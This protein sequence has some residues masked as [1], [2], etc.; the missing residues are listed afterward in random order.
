MSG[1]VASKASMMSFS[2]PIASGLPQNAYLMV[3]GA[4][5]AAMPNVTNTLTKNAKRFI[6]CAPFKEIYRVNGVP[7]L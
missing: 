5:D 4:A 2:T 6:L 7:I 3:T 1:L